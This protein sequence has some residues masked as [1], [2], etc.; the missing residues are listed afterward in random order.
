MVTNQSYRTVS[1]MRPAPMS[2]MNMLTVKP[3]WAEAISSWDE[4]LRAAGKSAETRYTRTYHLRRLAH[5]HPDVHPWQMTDGHVVT[6]MA[7]HEW[8]AETRRSYRSSLRVFFRWAQ[9]RGHITVDPSHELPPVPIP[10]AR[11]RPAPNDI[12][13]DALDTVDPRV[14]LMLLVLVFT[15]IRRGEC[16]RLHTN[17]IERDLYGWQLRVI[18]KGGHERI[19]PIDDALAATLRLLPPGWFFPGQINGHLSASYVGKLVSRAMADGWTAHNL[20]HRYASL[21]YSV[22]RDIRATQELLGHASVT[23]TQIYTFV[24]EESLRRAAAGANLGLARHAA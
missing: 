4:W 16:S 3:V 21:A 7:N 6:W 12:V 2:G 5:D 14:K 8:K 9:A 10:R 1:F 19:I 18:G 20:R 15:G 22:E 13:E 17:Q 11:P 23:T 24:P